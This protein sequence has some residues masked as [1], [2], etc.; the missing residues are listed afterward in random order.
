MGKSVEPLN[1]C[2][3]C[4]GSVETEYLENKRY[5]YK[6]KECG[7]CIDFN[8]PSQLV[9]DRI[10]N[11][12]ITTKLFKKTMESNNDEVNGIEHK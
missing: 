12:L 7:L 8:A 1:P 9:A 2:P 6:C 4:R 10:F 11:G 3:M 5:R